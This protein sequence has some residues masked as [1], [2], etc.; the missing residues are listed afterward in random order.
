M[1]RKPTPTPRVKPEPAA[2]AA[3][4]AAVAPKPEPAA[5]AAP[6]PAA[7]PVGAV[8]AP[9]ADALAA[10]HA[11]IDRLAGLFSVSKE[12]MAWRA[13]QAG[14]KAIQAQP[15]PQLSGAP[16]EG[17][18]RILVKG[19]KDG[20]Y[21]AGHHFTPEGKTVDV[22]AAQLDAIKADALLTHEVVV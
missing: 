7:K 10:Q 9:P 12:E 16:A 20:R 4:A 6:A 8:F 13:L 3:P 11:E 5:A 15:Q 17:T 2:A 21:R 22:D 14:V 1:A 19:P 18:T